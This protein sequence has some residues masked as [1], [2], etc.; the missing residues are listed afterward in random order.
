M[1]VSSPLAITSG[2]FVTMGQT[3]ETL[4]VCGNFGM[5]NII[6]G[7]SNGT[8]SILCSDCNDAGQYILWKAL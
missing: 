1:K 8:F 5:R 2:W 7:K 4:H 3:S 6:H